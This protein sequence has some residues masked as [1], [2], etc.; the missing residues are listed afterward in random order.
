MSHFWVQFPGDVA[1]FG[2]RCRFEILTVPESFQQDW[3]FVDHHLVKIIVLKRDFRI[4]RFLLICCWSKLL[5]RWSIGTDSLVIFLRKFSIAIIAKLCISHFPLACL[6]KRE[7]ADVQS[8]SGDLYNL[9]SLF[10]FRPHW[11]PKKKNT[12][13]KMHH[14]DI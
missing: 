6:V 11:T 7:M 1:V 2:R 13:N 12:V 4:S 14:R 8:V 3:H 9:S 5:I 10:E